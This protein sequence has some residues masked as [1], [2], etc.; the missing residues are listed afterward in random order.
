MKTFKTMVFIL[1]IGSQ[2]LESKTTCHNTGIVPYA[3]DDQG[4]LWLLLRQGY[5]E[6][7]FDFS[8]LGGDEKNRRSV[9]LHM[10]AHQSNGIFGIYAQK[11][12]LVS[13][14]LSPFKASDAYIA[15]RITHKICNPRKDYVLF[16]ARVLF[17]EL[18]NCKG[19]FCCAQTMDYDWFQADRLLSIARI[20][21][22][23]HAFYGWKKLR[24]SF[25]D[26]LKTTEMEEVINDI[27]N[28][29]NE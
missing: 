12:G 18:E 27:K 21:H 11:K 23:H 13:A 1:L 14:E 5:H 10:L 4:Q 9:A 28:T 15:S 7:W 16:F 20:A 24:F 8:G 29:I 6:H 26:F 22:R 17:I 2:G 3:F 25:V 19:S